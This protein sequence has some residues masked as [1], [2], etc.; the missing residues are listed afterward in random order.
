MKSNCLTTPLFCVKL[1]SY[2]Y[3][4][5]SP[6]IPIITLQSTYQKGGKL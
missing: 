3:F 6:A 1:N 2:P 4:G 5:D